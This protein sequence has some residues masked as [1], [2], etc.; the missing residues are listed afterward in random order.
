MT[1]ETKIH[2][3]LEADYVKFVETAK[4]KMDLYVSKANALK[5]KAV[6]VKNDIKKKGKKHS[7]CCKKN[8]TKYSLKTL[9]FY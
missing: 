8:E 5:G 7:V 6:D 9:K 3:S 1:S 4:S 2:G